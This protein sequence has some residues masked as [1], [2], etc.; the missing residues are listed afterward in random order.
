[1]DIIYT[2]MAIKYQMAIKYLHQY[3]PSQGMPEFN[4]ICIFGMKIYHLATLIQRIVDNF[5]I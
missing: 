5:D 4:N 3:F 1:M 2:K